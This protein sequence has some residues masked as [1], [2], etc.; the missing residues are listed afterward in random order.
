MLFLSLIK[1][2]IFIIFNKTYKTLWINAQIYLRHFSCL[3][4]YSIRLLSLSPLFSLSHYCTML[5]WFF[6]CRDKTV[7]HLSLFKIN[8]CIY[9]LL[10]IQINISCNTRYP[11]FY[12]RYTNT[13]C[14]TKLILDQ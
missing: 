6:D 9:L 5:C 14:P 12:L 13:G 3:L 10:S 7:F 4:H 2:L 1:N 8:V 11:L